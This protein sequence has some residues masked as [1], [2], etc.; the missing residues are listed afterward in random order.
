MSP[1]PEGLRWSKDRQLPA[2]L[3]GRP[4]RTVE[5]RAAVLVGLKIIGRLNFEASELQAPLIAHGCYFD[6]AVNFISVKAPE[7]RLTACHLPGIDAEQLETRGDLD[8]S[9]YSD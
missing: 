1:R 7:I 6:H 3:L 2:E 5:P 4:G 9:N 8:L